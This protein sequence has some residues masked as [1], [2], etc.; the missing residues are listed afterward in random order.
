M[1]GIAIIYGAL[2]GFSLALTGGG[3]SIF[4]VPLL[5]YGL[6]TT[7]R[8]AIG[9]S[10]ASVGAIALVGA[11]KKIRSR[12][13]DLSRGIP[14]A[15]AGMLAAPI[16]AS[17]GGSLPDQILM[18]GFAI[19]M[20]TVGTRM[21]LETTKTLE[22]PPDSHLQPSPEAMLPPKTAQ[23]QGE[24]RTLL[25]LILAGLGT[26]V[27]SGLFGVGGGF[28]IVPALV[29]FAGME[30][31]AAIATSLLVITLVS[32][33]GLAAFI[34]TGDSLEITKVLGFSAGGLVGLALGSMIQQRLSG[35]FLQRMFAVWIVIVAF[36]IISRT[37]HA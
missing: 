27:L 30:I 2:V 34:H 12:E 21:W 3:G 25:L 18:L 31:G 17:L 14:F 26:G 33:S 5:I 6:S 9:V 35:I 22:S 13:I 32:F 16:G 1:S 4:A 36:F 10:L 19:L 8:E 7:P 29:L 23:E 28:V 24:K 37:A 20:V 11:V 15:I